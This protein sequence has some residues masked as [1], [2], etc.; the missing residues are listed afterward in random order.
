MDWVLRAQKTVNLVPGLV[1]TPETRALVR[2][3]RNQR[4]WVHMNV[5]SVGVGRVGVCIL[6]VGNSEDH[7]YSVRPF[8]LGGGLIV[9][10]SEEGYQNRRP[11]NRESLP[12]GFLFWRSP[13]KCVWSDRSVYLENSGTFT[14]T[15]CPTKEE[16]HSCIF[17]NFNRVRNPGTLTETTCVTKTQIHSYIF[18]GDLRPSLTHKWEESNITSC[19]SVYVRKDP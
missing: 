13:Q 9:S 3:A 1:V 7:T 6:C 11:Y 5:R 12:W 4:T 16:I 18:I 8:F 14:E 15:S 2:R 19:D 17:G 10:R